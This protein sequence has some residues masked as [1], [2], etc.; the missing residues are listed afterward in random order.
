MKYT[1]RLR[2]VGNPDFGQYAPIS[3]PEIAMGDTL[4]EMRDFALAYIDKWNLGGGNH[5]NTVIQETATGKIVAWISYNGRLWD[6]SPYGD[7]WKKAK[8]IFI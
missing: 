7:N 6:K 5:P 2:S 1:M 8:E 4:K 3:D